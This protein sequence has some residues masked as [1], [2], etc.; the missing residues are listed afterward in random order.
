MSDRRSVTMRL[1]EEARAIMQRVGAEEGLSRTAVVEQALRL[2]QRC[3]EQ[4]R[5]DRRR[6][7]G[8]EKAPGGE[9]RGGPGQ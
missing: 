1:T 5:A 9:W 2:L 6:Y 4:R 8:R 7:V 3:R